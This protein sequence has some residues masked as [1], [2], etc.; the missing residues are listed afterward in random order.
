MWFLMFTAGMGTLLYTC[1]NFYNNIFSVDKTLKFSNDTSDYNS[2]TTPVQRTNDHY[3]LICYRIVY[4][5][6]NKEEQ[7]FSEITREELDQIDECDKIRF[8]VIEYMYNGRLC[9]QLVY[10]K[11]I[12]FPVYQFTIQNTE[13]EY[14]PEYFWLGTEN[15]TQYVRP[16]LG[17]AYNFYMDTDQRHFLKDIL[18]DHP[19]I[20]S[21]DFINEKLYMITNNTPISGIKLLIKDPSC[22][23]LFKRHAAVDPR[24]FEQLGLKLNEYHEVVEISS[25]KKII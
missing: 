7:V 13:W 19:N 6:K 15:I 17:P 4:E 2:N 20:D 25:N 1:Y 10:N 23:L 11:D 24:D 3:N 12:Q 8:V 16:Y 22:E 14:F 9:K 21:F 18:Y 5:N